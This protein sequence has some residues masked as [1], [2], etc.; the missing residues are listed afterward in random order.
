MAISG[1]PA[2][3]H[4]PQPR[5]PARGAPAGARWR[6][7][8]RPRSRYRRLRDSSSPTCRPGFDSPGI[9]ILVE[10]KRHLRPT[11]ENRPPDEVRIVQHEVDRFLL[12]LR[13]GPLLEHRAARAHEVE[14]AVLVDMLLEELARG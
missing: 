6:S 2:T 14:E 3:P 4:G 13:Q 7:D 1:A 12:R 11:H 8:R 10:A 9:G 5:P